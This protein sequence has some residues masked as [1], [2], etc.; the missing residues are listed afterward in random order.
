[1]IMVNKLQNYIDSLERIKKDKIGVK[2]IIDIVERLNQH[3]LQALSDGNHHDL[4]DSCKHL[5]E[6]INRA[7]YRIYYAREGKSGIIICGAGSKN[8]RQTRD[9]RWACEALED[10]WDLTLLV[11]K[12][13]RN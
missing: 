9:V 5:N 13:I 7:G 3:G 10:H 4:F 1:M 6:Y 8:T 11:R 12:F 2:K